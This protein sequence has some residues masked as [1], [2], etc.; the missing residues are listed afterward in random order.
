MKPLYIFLIILLPVAVAAQSNY[1]AGF[2]LKSNGDTL[3]GYIN[4][5]EWNETPRIIEFKTSKQDQKVQQLG[6][7]SIKGFEITGMET[8]VSFVGPISMNRINFADLPTIQDTTTKSDTVFIR[9]VVTGRYLTLYYH[10]DKVKTRFFIAE[11]NGAPAELKFYAYINDEKRD[12]STDVYKGQLLLY[13]N[14]YMQG[15]DKLNDRIEQMRYAQPDLQALVDKINN[16][17]N[18]VKRKSSARFFVGA[19]IN[20][21]VTEVNDVN[22]SSTKKDYTSV[23]PVIN[24][25]IDIFDNPNVQLFIFRVEASFSYVTPQFKYPVFIGG[26]N[27]YNLYEFNQYTGAITPQ[28]I[29]NAYNKDSFKLFFGVGAAFNF[30]AYSN[31]KYTILSTDPAI[32]KAYTAPQPYTLE[33][34][35]ASF[36]F[37][38]GVTVNKKI[39]LSLTYIAFAAYTKYNDFSASNQTISLRAKYLLGK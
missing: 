32:V 28:V 33:S 26:V 3:K 17:G 23:A 16:N 36:P 9:Q 39:E 6:P 11:K 34:F 25:G 27:T 4:Y 1:H 20:N 12:V 29:L 10:N 13:I 14:K 18:A 5:R 35:Y 22:Y 37:E 2:V 24:A 31:N 30:S 21:T 15:S 7:L 38:A 8:Y 19:G